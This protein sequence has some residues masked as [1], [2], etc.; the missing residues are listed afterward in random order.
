MACGTARTATATALLPSDP[1]GGGVVSCGR[2]NIPAQRGDAALERRTARREA[3]S[4]LMR[5]K[6]QEAQ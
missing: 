6:I 3:Q 5:C 4:R 2:V 1:L